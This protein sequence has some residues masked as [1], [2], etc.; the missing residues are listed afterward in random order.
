MKLSGGQRQRVS[1]ARALLADPQ[2]LI[3]DEATSNLDTESGQLIQASLVDLLANRTTFVIAHRLSTIM[4]AD[5]IVVM[6]DGRIEETGTHEELMD[7]RGMYYEMINR[8]M[9]YH[10]DIA[11]TLNWS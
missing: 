4:S 2:I 6:R 5:V 10:T 9:R 7:A 8:Q 1:I 11:D 3:L